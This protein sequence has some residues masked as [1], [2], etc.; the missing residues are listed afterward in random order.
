[1]KGRPVKG[2]DPHYRERVIGEVVIASM[3]GF[4]LREATG[5]ARAAGA[6]SVKGGRQPNRSLQRGESRRGPD[7]GR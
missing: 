7:E 6:A 5:P 4:R 2:G 1:M 3:T